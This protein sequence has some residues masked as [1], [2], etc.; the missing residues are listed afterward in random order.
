[1][2][3]LTSN[4]LPPGVPVNIDFDWRDLLASMDPPVVRGLMEGSELRAFSFKLLQGTLDHNWRKHDSGER[5]VFEMTLANGTTVHLHFHKNGRFD[6]PT[7]YRNGAD[8][9]VAPDVPAGANRPD[10]E[11]GG[12]ISRLHA[13][14]AAESLLSEAHALNVGAVRVTD[15]VGIDWRRWMDNV[16]QGHEL[17]GPGVTEAYAVRR[18]VDHEPEFMFVRSDGSTVAISPSSQMYDPRYRRHG[19]AHISQHDN[20]VHGLLQSAPVAVQAWQRVR[21]LPPR[22]P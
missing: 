19:L 20:V 1:M 2:V 6:A 16:M 12:Q 15:G 11:V 3:D 7:V 21:G 13:A 9:P 5:H 18:A 10:H 4:E 14:M 22:Q 8:T 17:R